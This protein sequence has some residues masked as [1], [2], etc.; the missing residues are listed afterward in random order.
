MK[1]RKISITY[2]VDKVIQEGYN[3]ATEDL[4]RARMQ[5]F[6]TPDYDI[7]LYEDSAVVAEKALKW[8]KETAPMI[9]LFDE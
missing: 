9:P 1:K 8:W 7:S 5:K 3:C 6:R 4:H 2:F